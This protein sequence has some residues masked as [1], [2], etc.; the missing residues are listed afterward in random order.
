MINSILR[1]CLFL[2]LF[3]FFFL[4]LFPSLYFAHP[5]Y[6][7]KYI[8]TC[9][10]T[11]SCN[12]FYSHKIVP[13]CS[14]AKCLPS[15]LQSKCILSTNCF[16]CN[17]YVYEIARVLFLMIKFSKLQKFHLNNPSAF[18]ILHSTIKFHPTYV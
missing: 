16:N 1:D 10:S 4:H 7:S 8:K 11:L 18:Y 2:S 9:T 13:N 14:K 6:I 5:Y 12:Q 15:K 3:I 17:D